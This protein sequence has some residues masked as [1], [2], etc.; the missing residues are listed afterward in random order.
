MRALA[1][2]AEHVLAITMFHGLAVGWADLVLPGTSYLERDGSFFNLEG[3]VQR[4]RRTVIPPVP[5]ELAWIAKLAERFGV[6]LSPHA[7]AV[8]AELSEK[9]YGGMSFGEVG[10]RASLPDRASYTAPTPAP[11][12]PI[13]PVEAPPGEHFL[14]TLKLRRYRPLFSGAA[15]ERVPELQ[16]QRPEAVIELA[17]D[18]AER[19][20]IVERRDRQRPLERDV[21]AAPRA[22]QP[23]ARGRHRPD[24]RGARG[25]SAPG[26]R[27]GEAMTE[28]WWVAVIKSV[29][30]IN[31]VL[32]VFA[33]LTLAERKVMGRMQLRYGPNRAGPFGL[34]QP[35]ADMV[36]LIRKESFFPGSAVDVLYIFSP[37]VA[38]F[39]ALCTFAVI[40]FG[41]GWEISGVQV[42]GQIADVPIALILIFAIGSIGIY[43]FIVGGWASDSKYALLGSMRTCAQLVSYEVSLALSVLGVVIMAQSL[44]LTEIVTAQDNWWYVVPQFVGFVVFLFAGTAETARAPFDLPEAEQ[45]LVAGYHTEY[46]GMRFGLFTMAEYINLI[47][48]SALAVTLFLGGWHFP[49]LEGLG[50]LWFL[51]KLFVLL[52]VF[53]WMRTTLPRLRYDQLM[54][55]G[56]KVLLPVATINAVV[57]AILVVAL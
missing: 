9:L 44:S 22:G 8:F 18:D 56:W 21:G 12:A 57:T 35:I 15:V 20:Q 27:G 25:R 30:I 6:E 16:F 31:L 48:L 7:S 11:V 51:L 19:R 46:G 33:Y 47:T 53:I 13:P 42:D 26:R 17:A 43:G 10:E 39:T 4:L 32:G 24:R 38:A 5:D 45:E 34:L 41:P 54:R 36:K 50:P 14:G 37:F 2:Q 29:I 40:P 55:F 49:V 52:F 3:R 1:E 23:R 28:P